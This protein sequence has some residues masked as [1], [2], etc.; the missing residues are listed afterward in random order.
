MHFC[1]FYTVDWHFPGEQVNDGK[2]S[3]STAPPGSK[4]LLQL[5][6]RLAGCVFMCTTVLSWVL[7]HV[8]MLVSLLIKT[9]EK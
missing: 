4:D 8:S 3:G 9:P 7:Q 5:C 2:R 1:V 6:V